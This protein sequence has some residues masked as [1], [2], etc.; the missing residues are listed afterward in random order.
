MNSSVVGLYRHI[1]NKNIC[2]VLNTARDV[3]NKKEVLVVY[4]FY[5]KKD[6]K[7]VFWTEPLKTFNKR[8]I[9]LEQTPRPYFPIP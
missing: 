6:S 8:Y 4:R 3:R 5:E 7:N 1:K 2:R 9:K